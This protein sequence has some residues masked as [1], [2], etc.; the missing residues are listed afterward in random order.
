MLGDAETVTL[1]HGGHTRTCR[2]HLPRGAEPDRPLP[3][4]LALHGVRGNSVK[5]AR[6]T[7]FDTIADRHGFIV[8]YPQG[9]DNQWRDGRDAHFTRGA[10][11]D[12]DDVGFINAL[13]DVLEERY[14]VDTDRVYATG[15]SNGAM[16]S[17]RLAVDCA[18]R[19]AAIAPVI[20]A[21]P[22]NLRDE[23]PARPVPVLMINGT[24]DTFV[25]WE[26]G[27]ILGRPDYGRILGAE[28]TAA[29]W[30]GHNGCQGPPTDTLEPDRDPRDGTRL[31]VLKWEGDAPVL[32]Y[33]VEGGGHTWPGGF[34]V[35]KPLMLGRHSTELDAGETIARFFLEHR[36][37]AER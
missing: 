33:R 25:P 15:A 20:G 28:E 31:R 35:Q 21:L 22:W 30:R 4:V 36:L 2:V 27:Y 10:N 3:L 29:F 11:P 23:T 19:F 6:L 8:A 24:E 26:G 12:V 14:P 9:I 18:G 7:G 32:L 13:L 17:H 1:E 5:M 37:G 16:M 34:P